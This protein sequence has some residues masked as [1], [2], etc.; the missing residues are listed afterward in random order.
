MVLFQESVHNLGRSSVFSKGSQ[1]VL[2][3]FAFRFPIEY[4]FTASVGIFLALADDSAQLGISFFGFQ[5]F[6]T[7]LYN[8]HIATIFF[9]HL[10]DVGNTIGNGGASFF[11]LYLPT[12]FI[13]LYTPKKSVGC[14]VAHL[15]PLGCNAV[16][17]QVLQHFTCMVGHILFHFFIG[18][19]APRLGYVLLGWVGPPVAIMEV[20]HHFHTQFFGS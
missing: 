2:G 7:C 19:S 15:Y 20:H 1:F 16:V 3:G 14:F 8:H 17:F 10:L 6:H 5:G 12:S 18:M 9:A 13:S 4:P 11:I